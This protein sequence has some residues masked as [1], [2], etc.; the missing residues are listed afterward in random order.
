MKLSGR[1]PRTCP[2]A[3][4]VV[5]LLRLAAGST[6][7]V[8]RTFNLCEGEPLDDLQ[9]PGGAGGKPDELGLTV[10]LTPRLALV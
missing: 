8:E 5:K 6:T 4:T 3:T 9:Q 2:L 1:F 7:V 10:E